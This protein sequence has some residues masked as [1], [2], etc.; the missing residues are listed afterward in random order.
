MRLVI[1]LLV[2]CAVGLGAIGMATDG[3]TLVTTEAARRESIA[4]QPVPLPDVALADGSA[5][6]GALRRLLRDDGRVAIV[7]FIYTRCFSICLAMGSEFQQLQNAIKRGGLA[8]RIRL[9]SISFDPA[10]TRDDLLR[11]ARHLR[12]DSAVWQLYGAPG[13]ADRARLLRAFGVVVV[14]APLDQFVHNAAYHVVTPDARLARV[15][16]YGAPGA[17]LNAAL[18]QFEAERSVAHQPSWRARGKW[19]S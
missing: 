3:F 13:P 7:D 14:P 12:A 6:G 15:L 2:V 10:D 16:N 1:A 19:P 11:Y 17:A 5:G 9:V 8:D 18:R 4:R